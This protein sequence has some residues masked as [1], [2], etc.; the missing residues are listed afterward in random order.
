MAEGVGKAKARGKRKHTLADCRGGGEKEKKLSAKPV[1]G[2]GPRR[3]PA[4]LI[5]GKVVG[6][7]RNTN[8]VIYT[9]KRIASR[10]PIYPP[11]SQSYHTDG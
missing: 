3:S 2:R 11:Q 8:L 4:L 7:G 9:L 6:V 10:A 5:I 1:L